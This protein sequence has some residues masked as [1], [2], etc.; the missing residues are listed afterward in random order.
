MR[1]T[2]LVCTQSNEVKAFACA[3]QIDCFPWAKHCY[4]EPAPVVDVVMPVWSWIWMVT[5]VCLVPV[6]AVVSGSFRFI[7]VC[8]WRVLDSDGDD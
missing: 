7:R 4:G 2:I 5:L 3:L 6:P 8:W 1:S